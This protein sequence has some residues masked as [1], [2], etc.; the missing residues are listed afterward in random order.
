MSPDW[1]PVCKHIV[2]MNCDRRESSRICW[3]VNIFFL[4]GYLKYILPVQQNNLSGIRYEKLRLSGQ[5]DSLQYHYIVVKTF[6]AG[7]PLKITV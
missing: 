2:E 6:L 4:V 1:L 3:Y 7:N 5:K